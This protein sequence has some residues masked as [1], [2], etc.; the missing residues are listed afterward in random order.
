MFLPVNGTE[1]EDAKRWNGG[2]VKLREVF[3]ASRCLLI[4]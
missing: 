1:Q 2:D 4:S 3:K